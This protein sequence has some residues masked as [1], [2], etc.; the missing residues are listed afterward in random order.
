MILD[1][2]CNTVFLSSRLQKSAPITFGNLT[3]ILRQWDVPY[4]LLPD[5]KDIW[6]RDYMPLQVEKGRFFSYTYNPDYLRNYKTYRKSIT[7]SEAV[8][9]SLDLDGIFTNM[10]GKLVLDGGNVVRC[11]SKVVMTAKVFE[12]NPSY[13]PVQILE[14]LEEMLEAEVIVIPW[15]TKEI[16]GHADGV[17]RYSD[18]DTILLTNYR[19]IDKKMGARFYECLKPHFRNILELQYTKAA[20]HKFDWAYIN[21]LQTDKVL[22][23]PSFGCA[24]DA[25]A[26]RQIETALPSYRSRIVT[27]ECPEVV[28]KGGALNCCSW[29]IFS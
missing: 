9:D 11:G 26:I 3:E 22:I 23:V 12:E 13:R 8:L 18:D 28:R 27:C 14:A 29:T 5:T 25:E 4:S 24:A 20:R 1:S 19:Q 2:Q 17:C 10:P 15:D 7:D 21:W 6:C 16:F